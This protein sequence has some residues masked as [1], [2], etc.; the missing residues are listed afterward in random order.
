M[1]RLGERKSRAT[2]SSPTTSSSSF[3]RTFVLLPGHP[4]LYETTIEENDEFLIL[5]CDGVW[6]VMTAEFCL[7]FVQSVM[8]DQESNEENLRSCVETLLDRCC[9]ADATVGVLAIFEVDVTSW[10]FILTD[11]SACERILRCDNKHIASS[12]A[13]SITPLEILR[14]TLSEPT[15]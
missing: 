2:S 13:H 14:R 8:R 10:Y 6:D 4:D 3:H 15:I 11:Y 9:T 1:N 7:D 5:A 12:S